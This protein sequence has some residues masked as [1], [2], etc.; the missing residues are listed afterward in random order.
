[1]NAPF[2][3]HVD[4]ECEGLAV[5]HN[6]SGE[7]KVLMRLATPDVL[8]RIEKANTSVSLV[9]SYHLRKLLVLPG[10]YVAPLLSN[11][12]TVFSEGFTGPDGT[13]VEKT[14]HDYVSKGLM[15]QRAW[16]TLQGRPNGPVPN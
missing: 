10:W 14:V 3:P 4:E 9:N 2:G 12:V 1:M 13:M 16:Q 8:E 15:G 7:G 5:H 6:F 11:T